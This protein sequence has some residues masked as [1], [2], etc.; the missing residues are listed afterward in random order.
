MKSNSKGIASSS[1]GRIKSA[2]DGTLSAKKTTTTT[3]NV[4]GKSTRVTV[5]NNRPVYIARPF[6]SYFSHPFFYGGYYTPFYG[7]WI[8]YGLWHGLSTDLWYHVLFHPFG[9]SPFGYHPYT[10][11][12]AGAGGMTTDILGFVVLIIVIAV[13]AFFIVKIVR[14]GKLRRVHANW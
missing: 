2:S 13:L 7:H 14:N 1:N 3:A 9:F 4:N 11:Y 10:Y 6:G 8:G 12:S 5:Y